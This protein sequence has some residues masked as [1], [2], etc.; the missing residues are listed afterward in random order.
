MTKEE[1]LGLRNRERISY[2]GTDAAIITQLNKVK[3]Y[4]KKGTVVSWCY[5]TISYYN[6]YD[7]SNYYNST[8]IRMYTSAGR[9]EHV[10]P[11]DWKIID[12]RRVDLAIVRE[13]R[14]VKY[15]D[16]DV[17]RRLDQ[18]TKTLKELKSI[19]TNID[20]LLVDIPLNDKLKILTTLSEEQ[21]AWYTLSQMEPDIVVSEIKKLVNKLEEEE[22]G[23][24]E[25]SCSDGS[26]I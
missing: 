18:F 2:T 17:R 5:D 10:V 22:E 21:K 12:G 9:F 19:Q 11:E 20:Y 1:L 25:E 4:A 14:K 13:R 6:C 15:A 24:I 26:H 7:T 16:R 23:P 8:D 3:S